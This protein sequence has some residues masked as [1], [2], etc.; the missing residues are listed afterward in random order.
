LANQLAIYPG[1]G[2]SNLGSGPTGARHA[3]RERARTRFHDRLHRR[4]SA[5]RHRPD[6]S[7]ALTPSSPEAAGVRR[8][9]AFAADRGCHD[10]PEA[11]VG[12]FG[13]PFKRTIPAGKVFGFVDLH[14]HITADTRA[15]GSV[16][17]GESFDRYASR[18]ITSG[19]SSAKVAS[20]A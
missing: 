6:R 13:T 7:A 14:V 9:F 18:R 12:A 17:Y 19:S 4:R 15:G 1:T 8:L 10:Y 16:I 5:A 2:V 3:Y 11:Q 20:E